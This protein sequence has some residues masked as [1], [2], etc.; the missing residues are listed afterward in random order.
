[1]QHCTV[2]FTLL[3]NCKSGLNVRPLPEQCKKDDNLVRTSLHIWVGW[4][5]GVLVVWDMITEGNP[6]FPPPS[7]HHA[8]CLAGML[9]MRFGPHLLHAICRPAGWSHS[10]RAR[11]V[12]SLTLPPR[13]CTRSILLI[14]SLKLIFPQGRAHKQDNF[15]FLGRTELT[16]TVGNVSVTCSG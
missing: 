15:E 11:P 1:M 14:L 7:S 6:R 8:T 12:P 2:L 10:L 13:I 9:G 4:R 3:F 16:G 5:G